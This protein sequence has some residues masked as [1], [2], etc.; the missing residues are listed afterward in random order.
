ML[1]YLDSIQAKR[2]GISDAQQG[3]DPNLLQNV[4]A[5]AVS[6]MSASSTGKLELIARIFAETGVTFI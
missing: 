6:A 4:T 5:T 2:T 1:E 3:L